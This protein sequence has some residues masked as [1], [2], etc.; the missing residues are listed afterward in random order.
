MFCIVLFLC[1]QV[2][3]EVAETRG[4]DSRFALP[5]VM[6]YYFAV[7]IKYMSFFIFSGDHKGRCITVKYY[8]CQRLSLLT[9]DVDI[10]IVLLFRLKLSSYNRRI[11]F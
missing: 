4:K 8:A 3:A 7:L 2:Y 1:A 10:T 6:P 11:L 9:H 5:I